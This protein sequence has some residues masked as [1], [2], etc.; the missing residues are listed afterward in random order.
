M[1]IRKPHIRK[2]D[3]ILLSVQLSVFVILILAPAT[4]K[5][6]LMKDTQ[7][8]KNILGM[9]YFTF[10]PIFVLYVAN[11][12]FFIPK[13][14]HKGK[15]LLFYI[16]NIA[17]ILFANSWMKEISNMNVPEYMMPGFMTFVL[18][19]IALQ[20]LTIFTAFGI[21]WILRANALEMEL[22]EQRQK[23]AEA[24]VAWLK[25]QLNPHFLFNTLNNIS[26]LTAVD[27]EKAQDA[28]A[29]LSDLLRYA[30]YDSQKHLVTTDMEVEFMLNY[31]E[32]M[33]LRCSSLTTVTTHFDVAKKTLMPP[34]LFISLIENAFKH[35]V[36]NTKDSFVDICLVTDGEDMT[37]TCRNSMF[38]KGGDDHSGS[39]IGL[40][41]TRRRLA[42]LFADRH[43]WEQKADSGEFQIK[44]QINGYSVSTL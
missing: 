19:T 22:R 8:D 3:I 41:N 6:L 13:W 44:I 10:V 43:K 4:I 36:S 14:Y 40:E 9:S 26:G 23:N 24:E 42:L 28:I 20:V 29:R 11:F 5:S 12:Y 34:L 35:G 39:G 15:K 16:C 1:G 27:T 2:A 7:I 30:L 17:I 32:L 25:N 33:K 37:F 38:P 21:R 31:I 18:M